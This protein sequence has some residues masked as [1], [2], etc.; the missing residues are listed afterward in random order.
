MK[1]SEYFSGHVT[2]YMKLNKYRKRFIRPV[3]FV[4]CLVLGCDMGGVQNGWGEENVPENA[5][6]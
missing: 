3:F 2:H 6:S 5:L 1:I 4:L